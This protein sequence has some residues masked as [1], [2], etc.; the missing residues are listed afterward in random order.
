MVAS[1]AIDRTWKRNI[2]RVHLET[3]AAKH[4]IAVRWIGPRRD[5]MEQAGAYESARMVEIPR[6]H[7][8]GQ[9]LVGLHEIGHLLGPIRYSGRHDSCHDS[10]AGE[11]MYMAEASAWGWAMEH[12]HAELEERIELRHVAQAVGVSMSTHAWHIAY[13]AEGR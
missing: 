12:I 2:A 10:T 3:L 9:Y 13:N 5:W 4:S 1:M 11:W 7:T 8:P 6:P